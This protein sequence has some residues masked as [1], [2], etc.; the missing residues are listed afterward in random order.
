MPLRWIV[1]ALLP[2]GLAAAL[3]FA[4]LTWTPGLTGFVANIGLA[5]I[6]VFLLAA[7]RPDRLWPAVPWLLF[8]PN[9][10]Y[11]V[12]DVVHMAPRRPVPLWYDA[13]MFG[14]LGAAGLFAAAVC[15]VWVTRCVRARFGSAAGAVVWIGVAMATGRAI[16][17]GRVQRYHSWDLVLRP[18]EVLS[19]VAANLTSSAHDVWGITVVYAAAVLVFGVALELLASPEAPARRALRSG[20]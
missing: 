11:L 2:A 7:L 13:A 8:F 16:E 5:A 19:D 18:G 17:L 20:C 15:V 3:L 1:A 14:V 9:A 4:R 6:P 10:P 12:S